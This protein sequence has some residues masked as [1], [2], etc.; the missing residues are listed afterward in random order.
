MACECEF[1]L[2]AAKGPMLVR[3]EPRVFTV[4]AQGGESPRDGF[5]INGLEL[6]LTCGEDC[7]LAG[8]AELHGAR[9]VEANILQ[10][11]KGVVA[12]HIELEA[13]VPAHAPVV[14]QQPEKEWL[15]DA[16]GERAVGHGHGER[17]RDA[18][19]IKIV[20]EADLAAAALCELSGRLAADEDEQRCFG[21]VGHRPSCA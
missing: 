15:H 8:F 12:S 19:V 17:Q 18:I 7:G 6:L 5:V 4:F 16:M 9:A 2:V 21:H 3:A 13:D 1:S 14:R 11:G 10:Q 20:A